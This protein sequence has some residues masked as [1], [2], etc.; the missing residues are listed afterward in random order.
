[1]K[2]RYGA[3]SGVGYADETPF[4]SSLAY[5]ERLER[6]WE[7]ADDAKIEGNMIQYFR[8]LHTL[9]MNTHPFFD[10]EEKSFVQEM[11]SNSENSITEISNKM[12]PSDAA[13]F[14]TELEKSLDDFRMALVK[15][16]FKYKIT[17]FQRTSKTWQD[18]VEDDYQ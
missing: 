11:I 4:N 5:L 14:I 9:Y 17:Y 12:G 3:S 6:R 13:L 2:K 8:T 18:Q 7:D 1:M 10:E 16:L 15:L